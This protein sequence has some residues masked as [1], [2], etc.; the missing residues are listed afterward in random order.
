MATK[1]RTKYITFHADKNGKRYA[2]EFFRG[3]N[4]RIAIADAELLI[5]TGAAIEEAEIKW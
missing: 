3:R 5:A 4:F 2:T 1:T